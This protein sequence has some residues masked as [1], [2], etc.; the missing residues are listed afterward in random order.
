MIVGIFSMFVLVLYVVAGSIKTPLITDDSMLRAVFYSPAFIMACVIMCLS[1]TYECWMRR[2]S[3]KR[4]SF[5]LSHFSIVIICVGC[6]IGMFT[7]KKTD[8][9]M[10][11][12]PDFYY[13][14]VAFQTHREKLGFGIAATSFKLEK[15]PMTDIDLF[16]EKEVEPSESMRRMGYPARTVT[17]YVFEKTFKIADG[18]IQLD[19]GTVVKLD[20]LK[21]LETGEWVQSHIIEGVGILQPVKPMDKF[22]EVDFKLIKDEAGEDTETVKMEVNKPVSYGGWK[23]YL[24]DYDK[25]DHRWVTITARKDPGAPLVVAGLWLLMIGT[26]MICFGANVVKGGKKDGC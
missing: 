24:V 3:W 25:R 23:F 2:R 1:I 17:D 10:Q 4:V 18:D 9:P 26:S 20:D 19:N 22:Y 15:Y 16:I 14:E 21:N 8:L 7:S 11:V 12:G 5:F 6:A 13:E